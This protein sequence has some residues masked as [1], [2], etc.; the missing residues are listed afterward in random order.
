MSRGTKERPSE[1]PINN[2]LGPAEKTFITPDRWKI[3]RFP[4]VRV[5]THTHTKVH[6][7]RIGMRWLV[8]RAARQHDH[9]EKNISGSYQCA[10]GEFVSDGLSSKEK[11][12][13][14]RRNLRVTI[15]DFRPMSHE[16]MSVTGGNFKIIGLC[17]IGP[18]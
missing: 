8:R 9:H 11:I 16:E 18:R 4:P 13:W 2:K 7:F 17:S 5:L 12:D 3:D 14:N 10:H 6:I 1:S 15:R